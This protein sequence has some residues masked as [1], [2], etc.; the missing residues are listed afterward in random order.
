[1][2]LIINLVV[3]NKTAIFGQRLFNVY[4][5][6]PLEYH[7]N[8]NSASMIV[9]IRTSVGLTMD[10][11][12]LILMTILDFMMTIGIFA[13]LVFHQAEA[14]FIAL[15]AFGAIGL[16]YYKYF[17]PILQRWGRLN[18]ELEQTLVKWIAQ[19]FDNIRNVKIMRYRSYLGIKF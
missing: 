4:V 7:F 5:S 12:R 6:L 18:L 3:G 15:L 17:S 8:N 9:N 16:F 13:L 19:T 11:V 1:M 10:S 14:S 2:V